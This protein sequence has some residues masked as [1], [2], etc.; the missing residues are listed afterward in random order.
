MKAVYPLVQANHAAPAV[1]FQKAPFQ[2]LI[3][4]QA[5]VPVAQRVHTNQVLVAHL[6]ALVV[7]VFHQVCIHVVYLQFQHQNLANQVVNLVAAHHL[8]IKALALPAV[9]KS[10]V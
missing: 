8:Q 3:H 5:R 2:A 10:L 1:T 7:F 6:A 9:K 4:H